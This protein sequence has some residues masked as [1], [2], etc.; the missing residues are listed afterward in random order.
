[1]VK[2]IT[3]TTACLSPEI[4]RRYDIP[5]IPQVIHFGEETFYEGVDMDAEAFMTR[6][7]TSA[8]LP[9]T[10]APPPGLFVEQFQRLVPLGEPIVCIHPSAEIS[11]TIR[12]ATVAAAEFPDADIRIVDTRLVASPLGTIVQL[13]AEAAARGADADAIVAL[14]NDLGRRGRIYFLVSTLDYLARGG[15]IGGAAALVG[16]ILSIKPILQLQDGRIEQLARERTHKRALMRLK[17]IVLE[18]IPGDG[19]GYLSILYAGNPEEGR[20]LADELGRAINQPDVPVVSMPPAI[21]THGG[22]GLLGAA[23][24]VA[25][26]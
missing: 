6:L 23:F 20:A 2:F 11:G 10:A 16:S 26:S 24:F 7:T 17:E 14:V 5:V 18:Q 13:A 22:P 9:K 19:R 4:S 3:D 8:E 12:S 15:R 1:M 21:I 25:N